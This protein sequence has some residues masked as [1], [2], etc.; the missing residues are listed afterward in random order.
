MLSAKYTV[1]GMPNFY[2]YS[3]HVNPFWLL[4]VVQYLQRLPSLIVILK[5]IRITSRISDKNVLVQGLLPFNM[6][7]KVITTDQYTV[8]LLVS[9]QKIVI[10]LFKINF[11][12]FNIDDFI[13]VQFFENIYR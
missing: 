7:N 3:L 4:L 12:Y 8:P 13:V 5:L 2:L 6:I 1:E 10:D 11:S 9:I